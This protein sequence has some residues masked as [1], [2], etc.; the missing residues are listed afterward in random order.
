MRQKL[1]LSTTT[2]PASTKRGA[3]SELIAPPAEESTMSRPWIDSSLSG[4]HSISPSP[5]SSSVPAERWDENGT[6]SEA[7]KPRSARIERIVE[8]TA[9]VA[10]TTPTR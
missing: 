4:R 9:P 10:P 6:T 5:N 2:A 7:G 3:H 8:P 1:V